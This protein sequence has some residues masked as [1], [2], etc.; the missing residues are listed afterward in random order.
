MVTKVPVRPQLEGFGPELDLNLLLQVDMNK[1]YHFTGYLRRMPTGLPPRS[2]RYI[3]RGIF[4]A[5]AVEAVIL[6]FIV[7][8]I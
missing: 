1:L 5:H 7:K 2:I 8:H 4:V 3:T 6:L